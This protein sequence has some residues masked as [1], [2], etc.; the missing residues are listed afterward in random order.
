MH[1]TIKR[2]IVEVVEEQVRLPVWIELA[3]EPDGRIEAIKALRL[4]SGEK[5][6]TGDSGRYNLGLREAMLIVDHLRSVS[7]GIKMEN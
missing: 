2:E 7:L 3:L 5:P 6:Y 1:V 4:A